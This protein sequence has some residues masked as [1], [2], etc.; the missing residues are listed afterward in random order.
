MVR[1][2][3]ENAEATSFIGRCERWLCDDYSL[4]I[5]YIA[6][7]SAHDLTLFDAVILVNPVPPTAD[8][9]LAISVPLLSAGQELVTSVTK[10][11]LLTVIKKAVAGAITVNGQDL[12]LPREGAHRLQ[13]AVVDQNTWFMPLTLQVFGS[14]GETILERN[15]LDTML[16]AGTPPFDGAE[17]LRAW[18]GVRLPD[19]SSL[20]TITLLINPPVD[21]ILDRS[22]LS[23]GNLHL[24]FHAHPMANRAQMRVAIREVPG[25]GL[26]A[27][28]HVADEIVWGGVSEGRVEGTADIALSNASGA[29]VMLLIGA[30]TVRRHWFLDPSKAPNLR[31]AAVQLFDPDLRMIRR[32][33]SDD[34]DP[35]R[36]ETAIGALLFLLGFSPSVQLE[37]DSP[38]LIVGTPLGRLVIVECTTRVADLATKIGKLVDRREALQR[39]LRADNAGAEVSA[40]LVCRVPRDQ[41]AA[42]SDNLKGLRI[43]LVSGEDITAGLARAWATNNPDDILDQ[44]LRT[45]LT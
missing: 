41:I 27:R 44:A 45:F 8:N 21:M 12:L 33:L 13:P 19:S 31:Y 36:F 35:K 2:L 4:D 29:L 26:S 40:A 28:R 30:E 18:L 1:A 39:R 7:R 22:K 23:D 42:H 43:I 38:D 32:G 34:A 5:R 3:S 10:D 16:R 20:S 14:A 25:Q 6:T 17:D 24:V 11:Q 15:A 37:T 9:R